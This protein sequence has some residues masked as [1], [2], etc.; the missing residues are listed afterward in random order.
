LPSAAAGSLA[1]AGACVRVADPTP[2]ALSADSVLPLAAGPSPALCFSP[3]P[4]SPAPAM[5]GEAA[6]DEPT[7]LA[8][9][10]DAQGT[11]LVRGGE[12]A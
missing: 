5:A 11:G 4:S 12:R 7:G 10:Q 9:L 2:A 8:P 6:P 1:A 3:C